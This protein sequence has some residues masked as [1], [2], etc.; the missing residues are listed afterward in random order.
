MKHI[1]KQ[2]YVQIVGGDGA[3]VVSAVGATAATVTGATLGTALG[4]PFG[5]A[6]GATIGAGVAQEIHDHASDINTALNNAVY[7]DEVKGA[8][9]VTNILAQSIFGGLFG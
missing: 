3:A 8:M 6:I 2:Q 1:I 5:A 4:G 9:V 7:S